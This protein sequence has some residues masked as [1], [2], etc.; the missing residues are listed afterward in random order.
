MPNETTYSGVLGELTRFTVAVAA[1]AADLPHLEGPRIRLEKV[2]GDAKVIAQQQAALTASKQDSSK[3]LKELVVEA[4]RLATGMGR[5]LKEHYGN[6]SE[7]LA[8]FGMQPF[9]GR[10]PRKAKTP[11]PSTPPTTPIPPAHPAADVNS[12]P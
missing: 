4:Q 2:L 7:K 6:R 12:K 10:A 11:P 9:R 1:N 3:R 8:E 5:F